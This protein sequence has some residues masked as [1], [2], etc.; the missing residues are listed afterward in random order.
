MLGAYG[1]QKMALD[2]LGA[3]LQMVVTTMLVLGSKHG[4]PSGATTAEPSFQLPSLGCIIYNIPLYQHVKNGVLLLE[5]PD[6]NL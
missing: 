1:A 4:S 2:P 3:E 5:F 6:M